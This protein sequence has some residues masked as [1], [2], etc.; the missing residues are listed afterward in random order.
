MKKERKYI[1]ERTIWGGVELFSFILFMAGMICLVIE[2]FRVKPSYP[3]GVALI[4]FIV[5]IALQSDSASLT[6]MMTSIIC[7]IYT[8][9]IFIYHGS[10]KNGDIPNS[11][12]ARKCSV[13]RPK[14]EAALFAKPARPR[15]YR[16]QQKP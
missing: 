14:H 6:V 3:A 11:G 1:M 7:G 4:L 8:L 10:V 16:A 9:L 2:M 15:R 13:K 5:G 12:N